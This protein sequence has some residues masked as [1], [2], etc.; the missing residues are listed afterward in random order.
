MFFFKVRSTVLAMPSIYV[1]ELQ[2]AETIYLI[3]AGMSEIGGSFEE[4]TGVLKL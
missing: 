4:C 2:S 3:K 1:E